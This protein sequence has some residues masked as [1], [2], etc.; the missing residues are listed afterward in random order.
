ML[1][2]ALALVATGKVE[3]DVGPFAAFLRKKALEEQLHGNCVD[4]GDAERIADGAVG[5]R[6][7]AL[8]EDVLGSAKLDDVP[9]DQEIAG[10]IE[11][12]D[13][14]EL[15]FDLAVRALAEG[16]GE[17]VWIIAIALALGDALA[18]ER[19][20]GFAGRDGVSGELVAEVGQGELET[21][22]KFAGVGDGLGKVGKEA[23]HLLRVF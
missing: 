23:R 7:A 5:S 13:E 15:L 22:G 14:R 21:I 11:F 18:Q 2:D 16:G 20:H 1:D 8:D 17:G 3:I 4:G 12:F 6:S 19:V 9:N 10:Q